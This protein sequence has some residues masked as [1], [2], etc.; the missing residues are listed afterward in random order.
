MQ[1]YDLNQLYAAQW[2]NLYLRH[3][4]LTT[5]QNQ[6]GADSFVTMLADQNKAILEKK[7]DRNII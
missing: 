4:L 5:P 7:F 1:N 6:I 2:I 3:L